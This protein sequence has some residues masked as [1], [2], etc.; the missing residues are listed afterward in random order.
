MDDFFGGQPQS[1]GCKKKA[2]GTPKPK[3]NAIHC[4][5]A[6]GVGCLKANGASVPEANGV[7]HQEANRITS[8]PAVKQ[9]VISASSIAGTKGVNLLFSFC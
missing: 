9:P 1:N 7:L 8:C 2:K 4:P 6:V 5:K 3:A